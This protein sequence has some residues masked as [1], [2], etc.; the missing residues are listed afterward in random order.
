MRGLRER[1]RGL[2]FFHGRR[3]GGDWEMGLGG[4]TDDGVEREMTDV[5]STGGGLT[6]C[7][8]GTIYWV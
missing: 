7:Y 5:V 4:W 3:G 1:M 8:F 2:G 6:S